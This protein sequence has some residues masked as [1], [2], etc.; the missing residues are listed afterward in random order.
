MIRELK[1]WMETVLEM[2]F[3]EAEMMRVDILK[4]NKTKIPRLIGNLSL[5][6]KD[7]RH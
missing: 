5:K 4:S 2:P 3:Y 1:K 7:I 6:L